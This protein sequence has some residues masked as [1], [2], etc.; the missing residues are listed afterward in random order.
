MNWFSSRLRRLCVLVTGIVFF[1]AGT[2]KLMDPVGAALVIEEYLRFFRIGFL[3]AASLPLG[4]A[5]ALAETL[6]GAALI[7]GVCRKPAAV[8]TG[9]LTVF[10]TVVTLVL[11]IKN[12]P[13]DCGCFGEAVHLTHFQTFA[14]N[15]GL[16]LLEAAAFLPLRTY[17]LVS[18]FR[19]VA[20]GLSV[21]AAGLLT[22][23]SLLFLPLRDFTPFRISSRLYEAV[24]QVGGI[25][26]EYAS[27][28][29]YGKDGQERAFT[30]EDLPDSTWTYLR[31]ET[32]VVSQSREEYPVLTLTDARG[33]TCDSLAAGNSVMIVSVYRPD[34]LSAAQWTETG[35][36]LGNASREGFTP[37]LLTASSP[38]RFALPE[39]IPGDARQPLL[40][41]TYFSDYKTLISL[42]RSNGGVTYFHDGT[43]T[44]KWSARR[45]PGPEKLEKIS[46]DLPAETELDASA[47]SRQYFWGFYLATFAVL[48]LL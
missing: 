33:Q 6:L 41:S 8:A 47:R 39:G 32:E 21:I 4:V 17:P 5:L 48:F 27:V 44:D 26:T 1:V 30:L 29:V 18:K 37:L 31:T 28:F 36:F 16:L 34:R 3:V 43:L 38:G 20:F 15:I 22:A 42:N 2:L 13:M 7:T 12:P 10:F 14:K 11:A 9:A 40:F 45:L 23:Y 35:K 25:G 24:A 46:A 19:P